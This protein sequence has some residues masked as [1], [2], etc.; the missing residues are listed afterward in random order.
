MCDSIEKQFSSV[1]F[2]ETKTSWSS[3]W[4]VLALWVFWI[5]DA[6]THSILIKVDIPLL[7]LNVADSLISLPQ[8]YEALFNTHEQCISH[9]DGIMTFT[10]IFT[11][12][13]ALHCDLCHQHWQWHLHCTKGQLYMYLL[14]ID[15]YYF[16]DQFLTSDPENNTLRYHLRLLQICKWWGPAFLPCC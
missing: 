11:D 5:P 15:I 10:T 2:L 4:L 16:S 3:R 1:I 12:D 13:Y 7:L 6:L 8:L 9:H 14:T